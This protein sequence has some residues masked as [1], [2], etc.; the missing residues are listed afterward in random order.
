MKR[1][2]PLLAM[3]LFAQDVIFKSDVR[4]IIVDLT[5]KDR[6]GKPILNLQPG[7]IEVREDGVKQDVKVFQ[8]QKLSSDPLTPVSFTANESKTVEEKGAAPAAPA[9][10]AKT[11]VAPA[12][13]SVIRYQDKRLLCLFFDMTTMQPPEQLR[14]QEAAIKFLGDQM[15]S[16]DLVEIMTYSTGIKVVQ[17]WTDDRETLVTVLKKLTIGEGSDLS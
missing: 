2:L 15:T 11:T 4:L 10:V 17:E 1:L 9:P 14:A 6:S 16:S 3:S 8:L 13:N 12:A 5:I 7:D